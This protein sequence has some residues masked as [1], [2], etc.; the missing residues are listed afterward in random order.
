V[1]LQG[2]FLADFTAFTKACADARVELQSFEGNAGKVGS[3]LNRMVDNFSGRK[4]IQEATL[5]SEAI[6]RGGGVSRL[7]AAELER[8]GN[9]AAE[10]AEKMRALG[11][12][13]PAN[14][15]KLADSTKKVGDEAEQ[16]V[17][18]VGGLK[19]EVQK[20]DGILSSMGINLSGPLKAVGE[21]GDLAG[22]SVSQ[23]GFLAA[24][25][26]ALGAGMAGWGIGRQIAAFFDLDEKIGNA[27]ASLMGYGDVAAQTAGA[28]QDVINRA[29]A[30]GAA[31]TI[32]YTEAIEFNQ[33][34]IKTAANTYTDWAGRM[35]TAQAEVDG[36]TNAQLDQ[37][38]IAQRLGATTKDLEHDF[39]LSEDALRLLGAEM[40]EYRDATDAAAAAAE[41]AKAALDAKAAA[42]GAAAPKVKTLLEVLD[43]ILGIQGPLQEGLGA[44]SQAFVAL[45]SASDEALAKAV[46]AA[47][48]AEAAHANQANANAGPESQTLAQQGF[49]MTGDIQELKAYQLESLR[50]GSQ[51]DLGIWNKLKELETRDGASERG[52]YEGVVTGAQYAQAQRDQMLLAQLRMWAEG[53]DRPPGFKDGVTNFGGGLARVHHDELLVNLPRGTDVIPAAASRAGGGGDTYHIYLS[54]M[55]GDKAGLARSLKQ[56]LV[57]GARATGQRL[58]ATGVS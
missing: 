39:G 34:A 26:A 41:K 15:Q 5:M 8:A 45:G 9:K 6:E 13:V 3:A 35:A 24:G 47:Q 54:G 53:K 20:F 16:A 36:L 57:V 17:P 51:G 48:A 21:L 50:F 28:K 40:K 58:S 18:K 25:G 11:M 29:I 33:E 31:E 12:D 44:T 43:E 19:G 30:Q 14:I 46:A 49:S 37:I 23:V 27:T 10:A 42:A 52:L 7:T 2:T 56:T 38:D 32:T 55:V 4:L 1:A 22:K